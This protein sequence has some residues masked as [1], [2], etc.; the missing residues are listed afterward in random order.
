MVSDYRFRAITQ[1]SEKPAVQAS[2]DWNTDSGFYVGAWG[3]QIKYEGGDTDFELDTRAGFSKAISENWAVDFGVVRYNY[4]PRGTDNFDFNEYYAGMS[5]KNTSLTF[6]YADDW[7]NSGIA[8]K[9]IEAN[10]SF[11]LPRDFSFNV[12]AGYSWGDYWEE[13]DADYVDYYVELSKPIGNWSLS[14]RWE[15]SSAKLKRSLDCKD[16]CDGQ[17]VAILSYNFPIGGKR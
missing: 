17:V 7:A 16:F 1:T 3:S 2:L 12:H 11:P 8:G 9:Y 13:Y 5:F 4:F 6:W 14:L 15:D 10:T